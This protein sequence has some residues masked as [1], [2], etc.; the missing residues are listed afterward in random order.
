MIDNGR[1][2]HGV[3]VSDSH[4]RIAGERSRNRRRASTWLETG[5]VAAGLFSGLT[6]IRFG[7]KVVSAYRTS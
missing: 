2:D 7:D 5:E 1:C 4:R 6:E 3:M